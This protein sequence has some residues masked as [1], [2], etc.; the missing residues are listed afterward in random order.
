MPR[1]RNRISS[2][3]VPES[4]REI[5]YPCVHLKIGEGIVTGR[6]VLISTVLGSCVAVSFYCAARGVAGLFHAM[7]PTSVGARDADKAPCKFVDSAIHCI[8]EQF[9]KK[10]IADRDIE[11]KLFGGAFSMGNGAPEHVRN[12]V[13]V[14][15][16]NVEVAR[17]VLSE[18][19]LRVTRESVGGEHG[20]KLVFDT[21][22]GHV[23]VKMLGHSEEQAL[24]REEGEMLPVAEG[25]ACP[26]NGDG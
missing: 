17:Q 9:R 2:A 7:L 15:G 12:V 4:L 16:R 14:G 8:L 1:S 10:G 18:L 21:T 13:N 11:L 24:F 26:L 22:T 25:R 3:S 23:W 6:N 19:K 20:R 5:G